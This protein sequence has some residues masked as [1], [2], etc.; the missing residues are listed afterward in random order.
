LTVVASETGGPDTWELWA[1]RVGQAQRPRRD[2]FLDPGNRS[3]SMGIDFIVWVAR[4]GDH[5]AVVDTGFDEAAA[6][7]RGRVLDVQPGQALRA[8]DL[9]SNDVEHVVLSHLHYDHAGNIGDFPNAEIVVQRAELAYA[10]G[11]AMRHHRLSHFYEAEDVSAVVR[12]TFSGRA[13]IPDGN[14]ELASGF[15]LC[16]LGGHTRGLQVARVHTARG[17]V[18]LA[19]DASH[20]Y[21]NMQERNPFPAIVD[22]QQVLDG[23]E[24]ME[25]L[26][27]SPNHIV[28]GHDPEIFRRYPLLDTG[29]GPAVV[30]LDAHPVENTTARPGATT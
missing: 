3:G 27:D 9:D 12:Q 15:E 11:P 8:L 10:A 24:R 28:P 30:A 22:L 18:V 1:I 29:P 26:A 6:R 19:C 5:V 20:F 23:Y 13:G 16:L 21:E 2:N 25:L 7:R 4:C 14:V 17:W